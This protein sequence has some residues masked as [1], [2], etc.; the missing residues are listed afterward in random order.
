MPVSSPQ[1]RS[2][3]PERSF[4]TCGARPSTST[5]SPPSHRFA[6]A[7]GTAIHDADNEAEL[8]AAIEAIAAELLPCTITTLEP[9][10]PPCEVEC[11][12]S[13]LMDRND[14]VH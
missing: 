10:L 3:S 12:R 5:S 14:H 8:I 11:Y 13:G 9:L 6:L 7:R 2:A 1:S 4:R